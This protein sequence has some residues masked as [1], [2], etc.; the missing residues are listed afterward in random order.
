MPAVR[1]KIERVILDV[2]V[3]IDIIVNRSLSPE[4]KKELFA[5]FIQ[6]EIEVFL[7]A[8]SIDTVFYILNSSLK[9]DKQIAK[10]AIL[11][12]LK[13]TKL[14]HSTDETIHKAFVLNFSD[15]EDALI[16]SLAETHNMD[17]I[18][19]NNTSDF[20]HSDLPVYRPVDFIKLYR[21]G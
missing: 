15:F 16:N 10:N 1:K 19:T 5:V 14:L 12:L 2:N 11:K 9:I 6:N 18:L 8:F 7:P 4:T 17:A 20:L 13:F 3:C 21:S